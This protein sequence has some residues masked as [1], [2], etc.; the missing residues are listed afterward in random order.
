MYSISSQI[1]NG[2]TEYVTSISQKGSQDLEGQDGPVGSGRILA[3]I[4]SKHSSTEEKK[5]LHDYSYNLFEEQ[6]LKDKKVLQ[7]NL[8]NVDQ[9]INEIDEYDFIKVT[10]RLLFSDIRLINETIKKYN[11]LGEALFYITNSNNLE[12]LKQK[13]DNLLPKSRS[14]QDKGFAKSHNPTQLDFAALA[15]QVGLQMDQDFLDKLG[16]ILDYGYEDQ[17]EIKAYLST[18]EMQY[19][20]SA[21][22]KREYLREKENLIV[23][24]YS[25]Y[26][27]KE[28]V[29]FGTVTQSNDN[30]NDLPP[31]A[32]ADDM[33]EAISQLVLRLSDIE[34]QFI[35]KRKN[36]II[37][38]PI[39]VYREF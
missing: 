16:L 17:F 29:V 21:I 1:F 7:V 5:F 39:A 26:S 36:E 34:K 30:Q 15:K 8:N 27:E 13:H 4:I 14:R 2:L 20:F 11:Q 12:E 28:F 9:V 33:K 22:L 31:E 38:D 3:N 25:R 10:G 6:I 23:K 37:I 35:G 24:K 18:S 19:L 32:N